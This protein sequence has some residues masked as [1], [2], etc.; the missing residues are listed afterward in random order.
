MSVP[1][2]ELKGMS[3]E[4]A[5]KLIA[6]GIKNNEQFL[7]AAQAPENRKQLAQ[8]LGCETRPV[9]ELANRA[10]LSRVKGVAGTYSDLL[11]QAG[12]DTVK[13]LATRRA[14]NLHA[15]ILE[16]NAE[17]K[18]TSRPPTADMVT[19]WVAQAK[20]LPKILAY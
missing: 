12:V 19:A 16:V 8:Q 6:M 13:E 15:K 11:E 10:D 1:V 4:M 18:I 3:P 2:S 14:D 7:E 20:E 9:L 5:Q 17:R